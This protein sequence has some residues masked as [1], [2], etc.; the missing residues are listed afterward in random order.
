VKR[1]AA[2][3]SNAPSGDASPNGVAFTYPV[4]LDVNIES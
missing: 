1:T 4:H 2:E 3:R